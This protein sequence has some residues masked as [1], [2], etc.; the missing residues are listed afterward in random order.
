M[1]RQNEQ[2]MEQD[3]GYSYMDFYWWNGI[4]S[5]R[6]IFIRNRFANYECL[7]IFMGRQQICI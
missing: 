1:R 3:S 6:S 2:N 7:D 4:N 5:F